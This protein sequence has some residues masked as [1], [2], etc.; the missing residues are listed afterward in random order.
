MS[1][2]SG[3]GTS[4]FRESLISTRF[5]TGVVSQ[6]GLW[7]H[8]AALYLRCLCWRPAVAHFADGAVIWK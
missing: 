1:R 3:A 8:A 6:H 2:R 5:R 4:D 7:H